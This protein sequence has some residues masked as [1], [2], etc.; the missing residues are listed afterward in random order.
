MDMAWAAG[1]LVL[2]VIFWVLGRLTGKRVFTEFSER[3]GLNWGIVV[4]L[5]VLLF[6]IFYVTFR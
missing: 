1:L 3:I 5:V 4:F 2:L 6:G